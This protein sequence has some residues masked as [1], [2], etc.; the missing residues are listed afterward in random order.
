MQDVLLSGEE[1]EKHA[2]KNASEHTI[3][4]KSRNHSWP[5]TQLNENYDMILSV[6]KGLNEDIQNKKQVPPAAE[7]LL[8]NFYIIEEEVKGLRQTLNKKTFQQLPVLKNG[9]LKG[10]TRIYAIA[11]E[12]ISHT[13]GQIDDKIILEYITAYQT[14]NILLDREIW[15][16]P[17][18]IKLALIE[19]IRY[20]CED[21]KK[22]KTQW[23]KADRTYK[24]WL[25]SDS[26]VHKQFMLTFKDN[27]NKMEEISPAY[28]EHLFYRIRRSGKSNVEVL[29]I[30]DKVL[31]KFGTTTEEITNKEH[32]Y[33]SVKTISIGNC[34]TSIHFMTRLDCAEL[35]EQASYIEK[36]LVQDPHGTYPEMDMETRHNYHA[37]I[38]E[39]AA[40]FNV[41]ELY[42][43]QMV[44]DLAKE[45]YNSEGQENRNEPTSQRNWHVGYYLFGKG[46][47][48]LENTQ[49]IKCNLLAKLRK[50][51]MNNPEAIY[52]T[53]EITL[54]LL[55]IAI[56]VRFTL[57]TAGSNHIV[58]AFIASLALLIPAS[59][60]ALTSINWII[61]KAVKPAV[62]PKMELKYGIP[63]SLATVVATP[64]LLSDES[65]VE[66]LLSRM[67]SNYLTN[68]EDNLYFVLIGA[69]SD[70]QSTNIRDGAKIIDK[71]M[72]GIKKLNET[73]SS[74]KQDI[75]YFFH[76]RSQFNEKNSKWFGWE[77]KR[78]GLMEFN[79]LLLGAEDTSFGYFSSDPKQLENVK[80]IITLDSDTI[81]PIGM[82]KKMI[83]TM[84]HPLNKPVIDK[85]KEIVVEG[86]GLMQPRIQVEIESSNKTLFS[87]IFAGQ[88]GIDPYANA[89]SDVYQ[90]LFG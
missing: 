19:R 74:G 25:N 56:G 14:H 26:D 37:I 5:V 60:I 61:C 3:S 39:L 13:D 49:E 15:A 51:V 9:G 45:A 67:E 4:S 70:S 55:I 76:R 42:L 53:S 83:G 29:R 44:L 35:F 28:I 54:T 50:F 33:Q 90:D 59:E 43:A 41:S 52:F 65:T 6:Y 73:Y 32:N 22:T 80:Y 8:D 64:T 17:L 31:N 47:E 23:N 30:M 48:I 84:A 21:I 79:D 11:V 77:R 12:I 7:W 86:Y 82:A 89:I 75:F 66:E 34:I 20:I 40:R 38:Q 85:E 24:L 69:Y 46:L 27:L 81:L 87:R 16:I 57:L 63:E 10:Q 18:V 78:G 68:R 36:I 88:G 71:A 1:L 72:K 58:L 2:K 62:F